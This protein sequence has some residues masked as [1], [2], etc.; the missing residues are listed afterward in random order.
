MPLASQASGHESLSAGI[1]YHLRYSVGNSSGAVSK[2]DILQAL[3]Y[4]VR[5][6]LI[7]GLIAS[8]ERR[9]RFRAK[10]LVYLSA[11]FLIGQSLRNNLFNLKLLQQAE[12]ATKQLGFDLH[13]IADAEADAPLGNGGLGRL[14]AC[15]MESLATLGMPAY[16]FGINYQFGLFKQEIEDGFQKEKADQWLSYNSPWLIE[17]PAE[18]C[19]IPL[20]GRIEDALAK[21]GTYNPM[22]VDWQIIVGVPYDLPVVGFGGH[23]VNYLRLYSARASDEFDMKIFNSGEYLRAVEDKIKMET[24]S[25]VLYPSD[26][27][28][29]GKELRLVQ[30]YFMVACALR[31]AVRSYAR[32]IPGG[33][34]ERLGD[35]V[36]FQMNDTH[37]ALVVAELMRLLVDEHAMAWEAAWTVT[38]SCCGYTNHT[39][40]PEALEKWPA[41]LLERVVPRHLQIICEINR[42]F[43]VQ[44]AR[45]LPAD[46]A[47]SERM[48]I[49]SL[50]GE[51]RM[52]NLAIVGSHSIN[53]VAA[54][55]SQLVKTRLVPDFYALWPER[56]NN[57]TNGVTHR[58]WLAC[59]NPSLAELITNSV[60]EG[61][62]TNFGAVRGLE[63]FARDK[64]FQHEFQR[65]KRENKIHLA[66]LIHDT[67]QVRVDPD[68]LFDVQVK[69]IHE[70]KRQLLNAMN[71]MH[72]YLCLVDEGAKPV[73]PRT[74]IFA[75]KAAP[76]YWMAKL[77]IKLINNIASV[78]NHD[79]RADGLMKVVFMRDYRVSL[80]EKIIPAA[81]LSEQISTAGMEASGTGN[82]KF[83]MNGAVTIGTLDG[84]NVEI[85][86]EVGADNIYIFGLKTEEIE[87]RREGY[88]PWDRYQSSPDVR[89]VLDAL[90]DNRF[91]PNEPGLFQPIVDALLDGG[92][93]YFHLA[94]FD[95]Y[96]AAQHR[97]SADFQDA[98]AWALKAILNVARSGKFTSDRAVAEYAKDIWAIKSIV[99]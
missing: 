23:T 70:Y 18:T 92:D 5:A 16:G 47:R 33:G 4:A 39:L 75:G 62:I 86:E 83:A 98:P 40:L 65:L 51:I 74:H 55:H 90:R 69:R 19:A 95:G 15:F 94:D 50:G 63:A 48:S 80:A 38:Q 22:W 88:H 46:E 11:E 56:F 34:M 41:S 91:C 29:A 9:R 66:A 28:P 31:D 43:L 10:R 78:V 7:D 32:E 44:V 14:A 82:M 73:V 42:R 36:T 24:V 61:W 71:V 60:G 49:I 1:Q 30:E 76:G 12:D 79:P 21:D 58:R 26:T 52:A 87:V 57:K 27:A 25:K 96:L 89:R 84:A 99:P 59:C 81:D 64:G 37:P 67:E 2:Q 13:E 72:A 97:V 68:S 45:K 6:R 17:R 93:Y 54:L 20:Y 53:G 77:I 8:E 85:M 35:Y 3:G